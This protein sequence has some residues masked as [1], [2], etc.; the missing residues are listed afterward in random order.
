VRDGGQHEQWIEG[1]M[2]TDSEGGF[3][4]ELPAVKRPLLLVAAAIC[5]VMA[6]LVV[7]LVAL[8]I[9]GGERNLG[10]ANGNRIRGR[11]LR[12]PRGVIYDRS[13][14][15]LV[16]NSAN[17]DL[18][19]VPALLPHDK[20][21]R[22]QLY[23]RVATMLEKPVLEVSAEP[24]KI[25]GDPKQAG[26]WMAP[27]LVT[28]GLSRDQ[29][30]LLDQESLSLPGFSLDVNPVREY[31]DSSQLSS[32][33]GY[34]GRISPEEYALD[35]TSY[36][37]TDL[38]GKLGLEKQ[39]ESVLRGSNGSE[40]TEVDSSGRPIR[41][42]ASQAPVP[43][44]SIKLT[45]DR[46]LE[47]KLTEAL[48]RQ[49]GAAG[50]KKASAIALDP[51]NGEILAAVSLPSYDNNLFSRGISQAD[52][53]RL[54]SDPGQP[55]FN[56]AVMGGYPSGSIIKPFIA[57]AALQE[58]VI[59]TS[60][61]VEDKGSLEVKNPYNPDITYTFRGWEA[62]GLGVVNVYRAI[63]MSSDIFFY[64]VGGGYGSMP[65]L[66]VN[67]LASYYQ[68]FGLG[69]RTGVDL[70]EETAG[71]VPTP[72]WKQRVIH[73]P[74]YT[75][76]TYNISVGQG[77]ILTSPLQMATAIAAVAN[78]GTLY[79]PHFL[80]Q[81][82]DD[83]GQV[84]RTVAPVVLK[85]DLI[86]PSYLAVVRD[87]MRQTVTSGTACCL[88]EGQVPVHVAGKTGTAETDPGGNR[89][90]HSWFEAFAPF[91]DPKIVIVA[92]IENSGEGAEYAVPAVRE[93]LSWY[94]SQ[95]R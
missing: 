70:P 56:K 68:K 91:E 67:R 18:T 46:G 54:V 90:P 80:R 12:A 24:E 62:G 9:T 65:G 29:A 53:T 4:E 60:T 45:I 30:L 43:G 6:M 47:A 51:R 40:Q 71:R 86:N 88:M 39:Y 8:Q 38:V 31:L 21:I 83:Q 13:G 73:E 44:Q 72:E 17:F 28:S 41:T 82:I 85:H 27:Q 93:T 52:Y 59:N 50:T 19:V 7:R 49:L 57:S 78:G 42:L 76:D 95:S 48:E 10:L 14:G 1:L 23:S 34:T 66:G 2:P 89:K 35:T 33:L 69:S 22:E 92:L 87:A 79:R 11:V 64:V 32:F 61:T 75:G 94:F 16:R 63:A 81:V 5:I 58:G 36:L 74:W 15:V 77:D 25:L 3:V 37:P 20:N 55:L 84:R 26:R